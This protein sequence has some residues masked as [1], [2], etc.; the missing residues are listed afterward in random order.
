MT[1]YGG[2]FALVVAAFAVV[3]F[4]FGLVTLPPAKSSVRSLD[5]SKKNELVIR[6]AFHVHSNES[7]GSGSLEDIAEAA[8]QANLDFVILTDHGDGTRQTDRSK[9]QSGVLCINAVE[10]STTGGHLIALDLQKTPYPLGGEPSDVAEDVTRL[11]GMGIVAH[12]ESVRAELRWDDWS[13]TFEGMEWLNADSQWR[14]EG[15]T[16]LTQA[17]FH[18]LFRPPE[19]IASL[20]DRPIKNLDRWDS[21]TKNKQ[22]VGLAGSDAHAR[23]GIWPRRS[24]ENIKSIIRFPSYEQTFKA[25]TIRVEINEPLV[26][27]AVSDAEV[28]FRGIRAGRIYTIIDASGDVQKFTFTARS[29]SVTT[30]MGGRLKSDGTVTIDANIENASVE[31]RIVLLKDGGILA[32]EQ[33]SNLTYTTATYSGVFRVEGWLKGKFETPPIPW[34]VSNPIYVGDYDDKSAIN[35]VRD[36]VKISGTLV[37]DADMTNWV[38]EKDPESQVSVRSFDPLH[39]S[40][41]QLDYELSKRKAKSAYAAVVHSVIVNAA[42][43]DRIVFSG[44]ADRPMRLA[45]QLR[46]SDESSIERWQRSVYLDESFREITV[47]FD[48]MKPIGQTNI[49][50]FRLMDARALL[51]VIDTLNTRTGT[52]GAVS[53]K[54]VR[55]VGKQ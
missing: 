3:I 34:L 40:M 32:V 18:Y 15:I 20:F 51:F 9:Y 19:T 42:K 36:N 26:G 45:V 38:I 24:D 4:L 22:V 16:R 50:R 41:L 52:P 43:H 8:A 1:R 25:L 6:G 37:E 10:L 21:L 53:L 13:A 17:L 14:D 39:P 7:D 2:M 47:F 54:N 12:P 31:T 48:Q 35:V 49:K 33:G 5:R 28:L 23:I 55:V 46:L 27:N 44:R 30:G 11:G 29:G